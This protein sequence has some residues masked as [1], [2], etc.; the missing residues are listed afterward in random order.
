MFRRNA[1][2]CLLLVMFM[3]VGTLSG[4]QSPQN[5]AGADSRN[6]N[7]AT[8]TDDQ[9]RLSDSMLDAD[10]QRVKASL[11]KGSSRSGQRPA[12]PNEGP[13]SAVDQ[14]IVRPGR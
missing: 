12:V 2:I 6:A 8:G 14:P 10:S 11:R 1:P 7:S 4:C 3:A 9:S 5:G 13:R